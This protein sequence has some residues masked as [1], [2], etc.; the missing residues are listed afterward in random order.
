MTII[1]RSETVGEG[2]L[3]SDSKV[4]VLDQLARTEFSRAKGNSEG[5]I[6]GEVTD[7]LFG[8]PNLLSTIQQI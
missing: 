1:G 4:D 3:V 6:S 5:N 8:G 7:T 2:D